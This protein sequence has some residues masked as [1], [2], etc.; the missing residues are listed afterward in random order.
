LVI[1]A[2]GANTQMMNNREL[3]GAI[4]VN[5]QQE[6]LLLHRNLPDRRQWEIPGGK[7]EM[8]ETDEEAAIR[9]LAEELDIVIEIVRKLGNLSFYEDNHSMNYTL[10]IAKI[11]EGIPV[12][13]ESDKFDNMQY[14]SLTELKLKARELSP[15]TLNFLNN[16]RYEDLA[17]RS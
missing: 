13:M 10:F 11:K 9:E 3:A 6:L 4:I 12:V 5:S 17:F 1:S 8:N 14:W 16:I 15:N 2:R 7:I